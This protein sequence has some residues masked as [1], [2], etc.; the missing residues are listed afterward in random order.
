MKQYLSIE[1]KGM[2]VVAWLGLNDLKA[3]RKMAFV[4]CATKEFQ[5]FCIVVS[6]S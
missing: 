6:G 2:V 5:T 1:I 4:D 3:V